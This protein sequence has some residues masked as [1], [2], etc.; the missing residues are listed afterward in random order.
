MKYENIVRCQFSTKKVKEMHFH[1]DIEIIYVLDGCLEVAYEESCHF[2]NTDDFLLINANVRH[3]YHARGEVLLGSVFIDYTMLTEIFSGEQLFF[4]CD[5]TE[6]KSESYDKMRYYI[7][8]IFNYYQTAEGQGIVLKNSIYYQLIY[9]I[10][11]DFIVKKGMSQYDSLRGIHDERLNEILSFIM[12]NYREQI[13][14]KEL[15]DRLFLSHTYLSKYIKQNFGMSF[16]KLVNNIRLE[17]AVSDLL[18]TDKT[19]LKI[20]MDNGFHNQAGFNH[21]FRGVIRRHLRSTVHRCGKKEKSRS[22]MRTARKS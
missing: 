20:A 15:A 9:L 1:Q 18:Y 16:L 3:E 19:V 4:W 2:L 7:R 17:H 11:T 14:L 12:T 8:Q 22:R 21:T 13:T 5:S 10:T 6:E